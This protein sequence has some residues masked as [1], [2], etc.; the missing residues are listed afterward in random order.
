MVRTASDEGD[1]YGRLGG[2]DERRAR[3]E[4]VESRVDASL[5]RVLD[6]DDGGLGRAF[7][8]PV[9]SGGDV[10]T[11]VEDDVV[12]RDLPQRHLAEGSGGP[13]EGPG[14]GGTHETQA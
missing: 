7:A 14:G 10:L 6:G 11:G 2:D 8:H 3:Y 9:Q 13:E 4:I 1:R 5:H 12:G